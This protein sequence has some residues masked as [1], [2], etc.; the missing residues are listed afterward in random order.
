MFV[1]LLAIHLHCPP[2]AQFRKCRCFQLPR[3]PVSLL[4][5]SVDPRYARFPGGASD[6]RAAQQQVIVNH[7]EA[8][9]EINRVLP[10]LAPGQRRYIP[11]AA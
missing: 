7:L 4:V 9:A 1:A 8:L 5:S 6:C 2:E 11:L 3:N 10:L